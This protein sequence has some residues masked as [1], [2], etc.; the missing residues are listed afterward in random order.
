MMKSEKRS[1]EGLLFIYF[2]ILAQYVKYLQSCLQLV[3]FCA[4]IM[5]SENIIGRLWAEV[6]KYV[7]FYCK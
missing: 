2:Y 4:T 6:R 7:I 1:P 5:I 3:F